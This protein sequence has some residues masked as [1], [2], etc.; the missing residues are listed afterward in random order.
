MQMSD[1]VTRSATDQVFATLYERIVTLDL[2]PGAKISEVEIAR[3]MDVSRQPVRDAFYRLSRLGLLVIRPQRGTVISHIRPQAVREASYIRTA[4]EVETL[5]EAARGIDPASLRR[6]RTLIE[7]QESAAARD[8]RPRFHRLDD[9][10]HAA[11][12]EAAGRG[13]AW[14]L[15][16]ENKAHMDRVRYISLAFGAPSAIA[17]HWALLAALEAGDAEAAEAAMRGHL[18]QIEGILAR[19][20]EER[21]DLFGEA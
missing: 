10:M 12:F 5:R 16:A 1:R 14:A 7:A 2:L 19:A 6:L 21:P 20:R 4:L 11:L 8:D 3:G 18:G 9:E 13:F 17:E 15:V